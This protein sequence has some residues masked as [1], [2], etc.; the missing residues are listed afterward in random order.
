MSLYLSLLTS[1]V[2]VEYISIIFIESIFY[3][4]HYIRRKKTCQEQTACPKSARKER[5]D[6]DILPASA[7][8]SGIVAVFP[9]SKYRQVAHAESLTGEEWECSMFSVL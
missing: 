3:V 7:L 5:L 6:W 2:S 4:Y 9:W 8:F 1:Y